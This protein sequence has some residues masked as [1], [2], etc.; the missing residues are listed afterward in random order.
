MPGFVIVEIDVDADEL[1]FRLRGWDLLSAILGCAMDRSIEG[2]AYVH[3]GLSSDEFV[4][5]ITTGI[6]PAV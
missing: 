2:T 5:T 4:R 1:R 3:P 6:N